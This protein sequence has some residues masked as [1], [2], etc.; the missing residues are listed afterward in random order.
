[1]RFRLRTLLIVLAVGPMVIWGGWLSYE[2]IA[3]EVSRA[4]FPSQKVQPSPPLDDG[5]WN[6][7]YPPAGEDHY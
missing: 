2:G 1:M 7:S 4:L 6:P 3:T 5:S